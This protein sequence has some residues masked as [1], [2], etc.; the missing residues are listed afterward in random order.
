MPG[1]RLSRHTSDRLVC[2]WG[3]ERTDCGSQQVMKRRGERI[4]H[5]FIREIDSAPLGEVAATSGSVAVTMTA[6]ESH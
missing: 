5:R 4:W 1:H 3:Q 6:D 2:E